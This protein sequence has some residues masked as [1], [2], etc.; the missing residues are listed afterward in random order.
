MTYL[1]INDESLTELQTFKS[2]EEMNESIKEHKQAHDLTKTDC[3]I[4]DAISRYACKYKGV[5]YLSKQRIAEDAGY[6]SR[7]TAIRSC[8]RLE[9]LGIITTHETRRQ[10]GDRRR[11][12]DIIVINAVN[13]ETS[14]DM[15]TDESSEVT[16]ESHSQETFYK[17]INLS[18]TYDTIDAHN[19][20]KQSQV[21]AEQVIHE[22]IAN[23]TPKPIVD[24]FRPFFYGSE[25]YRYIGILFKAKHRPHAKLRIESHIDDFRACIYDVMRRYKQGYVRNLDSYL[26]A[27][28]RALSRRLFMTAT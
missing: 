18:N 8:K 23:N 17:T 1:H 7:R 11:S 4:L 14:S 19:N 16:T 3:N 12:A 24:L 22:S 25:L 27:S 10:G 2:V 6:K 5:C 13:F 20:D 26:F 28:I 9:A 21:T 15:A